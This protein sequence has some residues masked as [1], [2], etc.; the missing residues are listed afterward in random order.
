VTVLGSL[1]VDWL[2]QVEL[3]D[4]DTWSHVEVVADNLDKLIR[5]LVRG[6]VGINEDGKWLSNTDG[7]GELDERTASELGVDQGLGDPSAE[8]GSRSVDLGE[9]LSGESTTTVSTP[10]TVGV[11]DD[12]TAGKTGIT[13]WTT[14]DEET[15]W[16]DLC[17]SV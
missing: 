5:G 17:L 15:G 4:N 14:D 7:V 9:I 8:V 10:S 13:L 2:G 11:N 16:L 3:L 6:T 1:E 12:L